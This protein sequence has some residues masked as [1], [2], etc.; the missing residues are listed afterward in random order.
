MATARVIAIANQKGGVGKTTTSVNLAEALARLDKKTL[1]I[2]LDPQASASF[3]LGINRRVTKYSIHDVLVNDVNPKDAIVKPQFSTCDMISANL[4]LSGLD[5]ELLD[6]PDRWFVLSNKIAPLLKKYDFILFDCPPSLGIITL[7]ALY[8][9]D[10]V[11]IPVQCQILAVDGLTQLLNTIKVVQKKKRDNNKNLEIEGV[12]LTMHDKRVTSNWEM[13][14]EIKECFGDKVFKTMITNNVKA[15]EAP[16]YGKSVIIYA[17][18]S[19]A[20]KQYKDL[21]K[22][23]VMNNA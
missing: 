9:A 8:A 17:P 15:S 22:E 18:S 4:E 3:S 6:N 12:L 13:A 14:T 23:L 1:L 7:N 11:L 19:P 21:A 10:S 16:M 5:L 2:D 20:S